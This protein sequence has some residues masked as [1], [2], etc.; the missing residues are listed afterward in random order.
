M[1]TPALKTAIWR[2]NLRQ[3]L[4]ED[5]YLKRQ[6]DL[7]KAYRAR[8]KLELIQ[9]QAQQVQNQEQQQMAQQTEQTIQQ[10]MTHQAKVNQQQ[11]QQMQ[12]IQPPKFTQVQQQPPIP[13]PTQQPQITQ[14]TKQTIQQIMALVK[15][16][17]PPRP[18]T[19]PLAEVVKKFISKSKVS[20]PEV[21]IKPKKLQLLLK[22]LNMQKGGK[23][24]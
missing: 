23:N 4:G 11:K 7:K 18:A 5:N 20:K 17:P 15:Q 8:K 3:E 1:A 22:Q 21:P 10:L 14:P 24:D 12:K 13:Q 19:R 16:N 6:R 2:A 9:Q